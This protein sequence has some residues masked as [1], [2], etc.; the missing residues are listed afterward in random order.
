VEQAGPADKTSAGDDAKTAIELES[1]EE[2]EVVNSFVPS[3]KKGKG[4][5]VPKLHASGDQY[6]SATTATRLRG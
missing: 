6:K 3:P 2:I 1:D 4:K 5:G